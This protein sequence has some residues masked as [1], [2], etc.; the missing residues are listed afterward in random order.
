MSIIRWAAMVAALLVFTITANPARAENLNQK[1]GPSWDC[2]YITFGLPIYDTCKPCQDKG[3][4]F[5]KDSD[6]TGHCVL[7]EGAAT[8]QAPVQKRNYTPTPSA[9][10]KQKQLWGAIAAGI[11][12]QGNG[13]SVAVGSTIRAGSEQLAKQGALQKCGENGISTCKIVS[14]FTGCGYVTDGKGNGTGKV[15]WGIG[16]TAQDAYN[17]CM[18]KGGVTCDVETIGGCNQ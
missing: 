18:S 16:A 1:Y 10:T 11:E 9:P 7:K 17:Q 13:I 2:S 5:W 3:M 8:E 15:A 4:D 6:T 14:T 12:E